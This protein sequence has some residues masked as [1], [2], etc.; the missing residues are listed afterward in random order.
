MWVKKY[1]TLLILGT[2]PDNFDII[3]FAHN[4]TFFGIPMG[5]SWSINFLVMHIL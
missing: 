3:G 5:Q 4:Y 1:H 2:L